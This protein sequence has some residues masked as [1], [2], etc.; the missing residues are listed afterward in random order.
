M[1]NGTEG[2][3]RRGC[4]AERARGLPGGR[5]DRDRRA[6]AAA[7][8][9][10][11]RRGGRRGGDRRRSRRLA[12]R[13]RRRSD[14]RPQAGRRGE[15]PGRGSERTR[16]RAAASRRS[17]CC[18]RSRSWPAASCAACSSRTRASCRGWASRSCSGSRRSCPAGRPWAGC[19]RRSRPRPSRIWR[20]GE[21][22]ARLYVVES[23][24]SLAGG[25]AVTLLAGRLLPLRLSALVGLVAALV[26]LGGGLRLHAAL[27]A[28]RERWCERWPLVA[29]AALSAA[30]GG[31]GRSAR[32][33][34]RA[35]AL[36]GH[37]PGCAARS[38]ASTRRTSTSRSAAARCAISM[39]A[40]STPRASPIPTRPRA[41]AISSRC[42]RRVRSGCW[43]SEGSSGG[44]CRCCCATRSRG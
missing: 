11:G 5:P 41:W 32:R 38:P 21:A 15:R 31:R 3:G 1:S 13:H 29:A 7:A 16:R 10:G 27:A 33:P 26:A 44:W 4:R 25:V 36:R 12:D 18:R 17:P 37:G 42:S 30:A 28:A 40:G 19:S 20:G 14:A 34:Q 22:V 23:L 6:G 43:C 2:A 35:R 24:G 8:R 9:A 39:R